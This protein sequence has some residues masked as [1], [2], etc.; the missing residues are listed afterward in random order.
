MAWAGDGGP[1][2]AVDVSVDNGQTWMSAALDPGQ[3]TQF[4]WRQW[5]LNWTPSQEAYYTILARARDEAGNTQPL[6][7][8]WN[9]SG[10][11]WNVVPRVGVDAVQKLSATSAPALPGSSLAAPPALRNSCMVCREDDVIR[12]QHLTRAQWDRE[13]KKMTGWGAQ[14]KDA[15]RDG[16]L[17]HLFTN[18]GPRGR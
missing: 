1:V 2:T 17:D 11:L 5:A 12:S 8:E 15:D 3:R 6:H 4:G 7:Q 18:Y 14:V 10:Y 16:R 9:P 13:L